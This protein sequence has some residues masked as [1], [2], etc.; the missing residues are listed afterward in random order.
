MSQCAL[1]SL[2]E[3]V[4]CSQVIPDCRVLLMARTCRSMRRALTA[5]CSPVHVTV[6]K[7]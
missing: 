1:L 7:Q 2:P 4:L 5:R 6:R 3:D